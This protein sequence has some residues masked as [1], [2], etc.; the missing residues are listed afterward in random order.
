MS[1]ARPAT[2][3]E[4]AAKDLPLREDIRFLGR[5]LGDVLREQEGEHVFSIVEQV[6]Q[7]SVRFNRDQDEAARLEMAKILDGLPQGTTQSVVR[8]FSFFLHFANVAE[9]QHHIRRNRDH[10]IAASPPREGSLRLYLGASRRGR[11]QCR[12]PASLS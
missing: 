5:L 3:D 11:R 9:D 6:R 7:A 1:Q 2:A 8:A 4:Q 12:R 10:A